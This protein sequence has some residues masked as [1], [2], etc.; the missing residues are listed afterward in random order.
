MKHPTEDHSLF[1]IDLIDE[2]VEEYL[3]LDGSSE[4]SEDIE[5]FA[6]STD[7]ISCLGSFTEKA[8][9]EEVQDLPNSEDNHNDIADLDFEDELF[10]MLDQVCNLKNPGCT[11]SAEVEASQ[12]VDAD[13]NST[14]IE[15]TNKSRPKQPKAKIMLAHL[16]PSPNQVGQIDSKSLTKKFSSPPPPMELKPLPNH[17]KYAYLDKEQQFPVIIANNLFQEQE[18]KLLEDLRQHTKAIGW[19]LSDL[20]RISLAICMHRI[21]MEEEIKP[22]RQQ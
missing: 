4:D 15:L 10:E 1:D 14:K 11:N 6:G 9:Y 8:D 17:L 7:L 20:P 22:I 18:D 21:L 3:Q 19:K 12:E 2:L 5:N 16:V 13:S